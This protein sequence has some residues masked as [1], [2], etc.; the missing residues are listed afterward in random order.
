[1]QEV[2][3]S[4]R[5]FP[6]RIVSDDHIERLDTLHA[7]VNLE[8][9]LNSSFHDAYARLSVDLESRLKMDHVDQSESS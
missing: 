9:A 8:H 2:V 3:C 5:H 1:M 6:E 7:D 4:V